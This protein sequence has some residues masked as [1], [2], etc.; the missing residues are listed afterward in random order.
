[1]L[2]SVE[3]HSEGIDFSLSDQDPVSSWLTKTI[4]A[5]GKILNNVTVVF[6][7]D[8]YLLNLNQQYLSHDTLTDIITFDYCEENE[9]SGDIFISI[10]RVEEN[11][12]KFDSGIKNELNRVLVHGVLHLLGY[13]DKT[14]ADKELMRKKEDYYLSLRD[15]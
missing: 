15:F 14:P 10:E 12:N 4:E 6:C 7:G 11:A 13:A 5:E 9:V 8:E 2:P 3:F 1:M